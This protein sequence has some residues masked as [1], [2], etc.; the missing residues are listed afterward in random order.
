MVFPDICR[1]S[2]VMEL[3]KAVL[4][5]DDEVR[6]RKM[7]ARYLSQKGYAV[8]EAGDGIEALGIMEDEVMNLVVLDLMMP[9]L[10]GE[11][12]IKEV[13]KKSDVY[14]IVLTA[15]TGEDAQVY[16]YSIGADDYI[17]KP[18]SC[19]ALVS[20]IT[21]I[22][23]RLDQKLYGTG[24]RKIE[25]I[26]LNN[27]SHEM[28]VDGK[29]IDLKPKE[30]ELL[31]YFMINQNLALSR[32]QI[33]DDVWGADYEGSDRTVDIHVSNLRR[34]LGSYGDYIRTVTGYGYRFEV[35]K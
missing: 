33:L 27:S 18:F 7:I 19:K 9:R 1:L 29:R 11:G 10:D 17:E 21:A 31:Y 30:Y 25:G 12:F 35:E 34:K 28:T 15:K 24:I 6:I 20:K 3:G 13:R 16:Y 2:E 22:F 23:S 5:V 32:E 4:V 14:I 26:A 8:F